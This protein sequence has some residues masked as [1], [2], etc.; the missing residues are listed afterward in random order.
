[1]AEKRESVLRVWPTVDCPH[2]GGWSTLLS[3]CEA[4][5]LFCRLP[6]KIEKKE[7]E[8]MKLEWMDGGSCRS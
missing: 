6:F 7:K 3:M 2:S 8:D 4:Q 1:M 5:I